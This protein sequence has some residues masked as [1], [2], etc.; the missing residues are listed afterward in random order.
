MLEPQTGQTRDLS[1]EKTATNN[2]TER[3][4][5]QMMMIESTEANLLNLICI[6]DQL[7]T[8]TLTT[9]LFH[10]PCVKGMREHKRLSSK[11]E[12]VLVR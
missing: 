4:L 7:V 3:Q 10:Q 12:P 8:L 6:V 11:L 2:N 9:D 5:P 1:Q